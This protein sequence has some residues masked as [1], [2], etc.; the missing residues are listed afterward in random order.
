M[1][2]STGPAP[3]CE[4]R[5]VHALVLRELMRL[6]ANPGQVAML[7]L[8]P[9]LFLFTLGGGLS[10]LVPDHAVGGSYRSYLFPG[11]LLMSIQAPAL[12]V[13][14]RLIIDRDSGVLRETLVA[15][16][17]RTT[18]LCGICLG[19]CVS[20]AAQGAVLIAL[21]PA[22]GL[23]YRP[24]LLLGLLAQLTLCAFALTA[25]GTAIAVRIRRAETFALLLSLTSAPFLFTSGAF[26]PRSALPGWL[27]PLAAVNP[28]AYACDALHGTIR[29]LAGHPATADGAGRL[30]LAANTAALL[31]TGLIA[32]Y[33]GARSFDRHQATD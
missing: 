13:G 30:P 3:R 21:A 19:G 33:L 9:L 2:S 18:L 22:G 29:A 5:A 8:Q 6:T 26:V 32:L 11:V 12:N 31:L 20:A 10:T 7:M 28:L 23:P 17:R 24:L 1:S 4:L 27:D 25:L 15:P 14:F 16:A